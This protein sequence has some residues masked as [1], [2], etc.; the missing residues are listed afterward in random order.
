[1]GTNYS[2]K[3]GPLSSATP[4]KPDIEMALD[5]LHDRSDRV[6][7][8]AGI[9]AGRLVAVCSPEETSKPEER[10]AGERMCAVAHSIGTCNESIHQ[11][12]RVLED[13]LNRL[14]L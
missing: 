7:E 8:V 1:M 4:K 9:L 6:L 5:S 12:I 13:I 2:A 10:D 14:E 11:T 3:E